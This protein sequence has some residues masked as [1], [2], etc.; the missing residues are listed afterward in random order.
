M[1]TAE[2]VTAL[3][4]N[5]STENYGLGSYDS[6]TTTLYGGFF[7]GLGGTVTY[8]IANGANGATLE[9]ESVSALAENGGDDNYGLHN[10]SGAVTTVRGGSFTG[11]GGTNA[12]GIAN[13][14][15]G[16]T[17]EAAGVTALAANGSSNNDGLYQDGGSVS[18]GVSQLDGNA[19]RISGTLTCFQVY[20]GS[21]VGYTCP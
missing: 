19:T 16:T 3:G 10:F 9:A 4:K 12:Y 18:L 8:G 20:N 21:Y 1:L 15:S 13:I 6:A 2:G 7:S 5:G 14:D 17:L 11:R